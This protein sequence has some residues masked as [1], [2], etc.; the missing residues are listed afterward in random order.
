MIDKEKIPE[1]L[2]HELVELMGYD[3]AEKYLKENGYNYHGTSLKILSERYKRRYGKRF[4]IYF[5]IIIAL[6]VTIIELLRYHLII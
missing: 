6:I 1:P 3:A 5:W 2:Y 4:W